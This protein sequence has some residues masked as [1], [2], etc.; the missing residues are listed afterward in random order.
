MYY[1]LLCAYFQLF[2]GSETPYHSS[3]SLLSAVALKGEAK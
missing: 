1:T 3:R 2:R